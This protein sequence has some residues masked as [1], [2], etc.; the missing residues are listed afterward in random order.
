MSRTKKEVKRG[1]G[2]P[3]FDVG[4]KVVRSAHPFKNKFRQTKRPH[5]GVIQSVIIKLNASNYKEYYYQVKWGKSNSLSV[6]SQ[7]RL[8]FA[9]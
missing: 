9:P 8:E 7:R 4:D 3:R 2:L 1:T 5:I 6:N